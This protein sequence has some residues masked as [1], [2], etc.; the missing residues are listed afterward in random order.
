MAK[1]PTS[2]SI[3]F[4]HL[5]YLLFAVSALSSISFI[6][7]S[8][9][10]TCSCGADPSP[11]SL[12]QHN[13]SINLLSFPSAWNHLSFSSTP[14]R[15]LLKIALFVKRWPQRNLAGG[16]ER[17]ALTLHLALARRGHEVHVFTTTTSSN[18][19]NL[20]TTLRFHFTPPSPGGYLNQALA[21]Q[22]FQTQNSTD[23]KP[24]DVVHTESVGLFHGRARNLSHL[25]VSWHGIAYETI[26]SDIVQDLL[27]GPNETRQSVLT[28]RLVK[29]IEEVKFFNRYS[30]HVATSDHVGDVL[31]RIYMIPEDRVHIIVN[32]VDETIYKPDSTRGKDFLR[33]AGVPENAT[34]VIGMAGRLVKDKGHP[35]I[36]EALKQIYVEDENFKRDV[37]VLVA[38][39][40]PWGSRYRDLGP[41]LRVLGLLEQTQLASFYNSLDVFINPTLRAQGLDHTFIEAMLSGKPVMGTRFASI[42]GSLIVGSDIGYTFLPTVGSLK[43]SLYMM[44]RDGRDVLGIKGKVARNRA[45]QLFTATKMATA[46]ERL[47]LCISTGTYEKNDDKYDYCKYP[48]PLD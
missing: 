8:H 33:E 4:H 25:A 35:L 27:R 7:W 32:G 13:Q 10:S 23:N 31:K 6:Y 43:E 5:C 38:G 21:W 36:F 28:E 16:L 14:P 19:T 3:T 34:L 26:H 44:F 12:H 2:S 30:H 42:T 41:N 11:I 9:C 20:N 22:Q 29:V 40:G 39:D 46:Y 37:F 17:H 45:V 1:D 15:K 48:L 24:F 47:F 18:S